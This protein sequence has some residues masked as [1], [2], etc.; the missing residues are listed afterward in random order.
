MK[1]FFVDKSY[2][3][4]IVIFVVATALIFFLMGL[5]Y[6]HVQKQNDN[7]EW[8]THSY[9]VT[10]NLELLD[11][12]LKDLEVERRNFILAKENTSKKVISEK[13]KKVKIIV[14]TLNELI[15]DNPEQIEK[16]Q[17]LQ[18]MIDY[19]QKI[20]KNLNS[21]KI[22]DHD[23]ESTKTILLSG[24]NVTESMHNKISEM[25]SIEKLILEKRKEEFI[26]SQKSTPIYFYIISLFSLGLLIFTFLKINREVNLQKKINQ[27][28]Q[29]SL[30]T[31]NLAEQVGGYGIWIL[32]HDTGKYFFSD[33]EYRILGYTPQS[34]EANYENFVKHIHPEDIEKVEKKS[35]L[36]IE[37]GIMDPF[38]YRIIRRDG[39]LRHFQVVGRTVTNQNN[40]KILLGITTDV[41]EE[42]ENQIKLEEI[43]QMLTEQNKNLTISYETFGE[44]EKIGMFGTWQWFIDENKYNFSENLLLLYG[45][46]IK[47]KI[48]TL[49]SLF[50]NT[51]PDDD[52]LIERKKQKLKSQESWDPFVYRIYRK[53]DG[54][55]RYLSVN[56]RLINNDPIIGNCFLVTV[57]DVTQEIA[58]QKTLQEQNK[59]LEANNKELQGFNY[60]A[61]HD[62]QEPLRKIETFISRV[63][64]KEFEK[65][66]DSGKKYISRIQFSADRMRKLINDLL[67]FSRTTRGEQVYANVDLNIQMQDA[68]DEL[69]HQI[70][71]KNAKI[72]YEKLPVIWGIPYQI[73]Q[74]FINLISNS[75]KY[76]K[77]NIDPEIQ[78]SVDRIL[79]NSEH[80]IPEKNTAFY[81]IT[82]RDNGIG[83]EQQYAERIFTLFNRLH[84]KMEYEGTG[85]GLAICKKIV[86]NHNGYIFAEGNPNIGATFT[87]YLPDNDS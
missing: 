37:G 57:R 60:V 83:F 80:K 11:S 22:A 66:S 77:E 84:G 69:Q 71:D 10:T 53:N 6:K 3:L 38:R 35:R 41:T 63:Q 58:D 50:Q 40:E 24:A 64:E 87:V 61:S 20:V 85:I 59:I 39:A 5:T 46:D 19:H 30:E 18:M 4:L 48:E 79:P 12:S 8:M 78:I 45:F 72:N 75:I 55:L 1:N 23:L 36:M 70:Q 67:Q 26:F 15:A 74:L 16:M 43:N 62:L 86:E 44:V 32:N 47:N 56:S 14:K 29:L 68:I 82:F 9:D 33:N 49:E 31:S 28:L 73:Q 25:L 51:H 2:F 42:I 21:E 27:Q 13:I 52:F 7:S 34:F 54:V 65:L 17:S 76:A 81:K